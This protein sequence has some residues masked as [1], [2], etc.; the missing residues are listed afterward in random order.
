VKGT[1]RILSENF[2]SLIASCSAQSI[3][4]Y[5]IIIILNIKYETK[6]ILQKPKEMNKIYSPKKMK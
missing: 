2:G 3:L 6:K 5:K 1:Q 4:V